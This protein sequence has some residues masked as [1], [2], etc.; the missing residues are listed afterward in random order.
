MAE[1]TKVAGG[2]MCG[3]VRYS[4][5][6]EPSRVL[7]CHCQSCRTHTGAPVATLAV[8]KADLV[9][10]SGGERKIYNSSPGV[11]RAFCA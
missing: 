2:C 11:G 3:A 4:T 6:G 8:F 9:E 10:F 1:A 7:H 5:R